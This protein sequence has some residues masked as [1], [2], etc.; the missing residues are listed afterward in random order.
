MEDSIISHEIVSDMHTILPPLVVLDVHQSDT[1]ASS[2]SPTE[3]TCGSIVIPLLNDI[4]DSAKCLEVAEYYHGGGKCDRSA[5][6]LNTSVEENECQLHEDDENDQH[7][8]YDN[9]RHSD[10]SQSSGGDDAYSSN[11]PSALHNYIQQKQNLN[12]ENENEIILGHINNTSKNNFQ[13]DPG[14]NSECSNDDDFALPYSI[15]NSIPNFNSSDC[16]VDRSWSS[17]EECSATGEASCSE[18]VQKVSNID[19]STCLT[20]MLNVFCFCDLSF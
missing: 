20:S 1:Q 18:L 9:Q 16:D 13:S 6:D 19:D 5:N 8:N 17:N 11:C 4:R 12:K 15:S 7:D 10:V 2:D 14:S 3:D